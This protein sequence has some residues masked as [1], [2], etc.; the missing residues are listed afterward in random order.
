MSKKLE[1]EEKIMNCLE[2][3]GCQMG[4][5]ITKLSNLEAEVFRLNENINKESKQIILKQ[6]IKQ[7]P[8][9][10]L[11]A[12]VEIVANDLFTTQEEIGWQIA[13]NL[14]T[15]TEN[16]LIKEENLSNKQNQANEET[17]V[18]HQ[19]CESDNCND[20][21]HNHYQKMMETMKQSEIS[22]VEMSDIENQDPENENKDGL[23]S[24]TNNSLRWTQILLIWQLCGR[25]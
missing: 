20:K 3:L 24:S 15:S 17:S 5:I 21:K 18:Q 8:H 6:E 19:K 22:E 2:E 12:E 9:S 4:L 13:Q 7:E 25:K 14:Q 16:Q 1:N 10:Q 23:L 11:E